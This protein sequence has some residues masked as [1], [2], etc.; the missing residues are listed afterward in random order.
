MKYTIYKITNIVNNKIYVGKHQTLDVND[1]YYGSGNLLKKAIKKYG[2]EF[3]KKEILYIFDSEEEMN[4]KEKE[5]ITEDFVKRSD[6]YNMGVGGEGGPHFKGKKHTVDSKRKKSESSKGHPGRIVSEKQKM[7]LSIK[8]RK[9]FS[10]QTIKNPHK[11][12]RWICCQHSKESKRINIY[13]DIPDGWIVGRLEKTNY[14]N[15][16]N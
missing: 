13:D 14:K 5:L 8:L 3:F 7:D 6:T 10:D 4:N 1:S 2:I 15:I 11:G 12:K 16:C 9:M